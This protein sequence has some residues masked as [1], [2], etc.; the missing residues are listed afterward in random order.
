[1]A[2]T[3]KNPAL[4]HVES[5]NK[6]MKKKK[7]GKKVAKAYGIYLHRVL[8][9]V[10][11]ETGI[12]SKGMA[13]MN[14]MMNDVFDRLAE[15]GARLAKYN[16]KQT[17]SSREIQTAAR[18]VLPGELAKHAVSEGTKAVSKYTSSLK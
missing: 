6:N 2:R 1:M 14:S 4:T 17:I 15:E 12:S 10:S 5:D 11:P 16:S 13:V 7:T 18:L 8:K 3:K 9:Q